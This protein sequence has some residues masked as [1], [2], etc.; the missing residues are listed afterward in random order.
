MNPRVTK[1]DDI[2]IMS[3]GSTDVIEMGDSV[4]V[5]PAANVFAV[6][7]EKAIFIEDEFDLQDY[8]IF[9]VPIPQPSV[10]EQIETFTTYDSPSIHVAHISI[11]SIAGSSIVHLGSSKTITSE[12]RVK[13]I[14]HL[15]R[16]KE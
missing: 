1:V 13:N 9:T 11:R 5:S 6:Q 8:P 7:R 14:R 12:A 10:H 2:R 15:L 16:G 3:V 4:Q